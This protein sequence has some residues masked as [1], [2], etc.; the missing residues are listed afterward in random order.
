MSKQRKK[1]RQRWRTRQGK[2]SFTGTS[3]EEAGKKQTKQE[4][5]KEENQLDDEVDDV[6]E[7]EEARGVDLLGVREE[8][9]ASRNECRR[10]HEE[11]RRLEDVVT[12][13]ETENRQLLE[14][15]GKK[16]FLENR[17][18][19][20]ERVRQWRETLMQTPR[21]PPSPPSSHR[22]SPSPSPSLPLTTPPSPSPLPAPSPLPPPSHSLPLPPSSLVSPPLPQPR[23]LPL[24]RISDALSWEEC[25]QLKRLVESEIEEAVLCEMEKPLDL[26]EELEARERLSVGRLDQL[27]RAIQRFDLCERL[28]I[29]E[30]PTKAASI[31]P[32]AASYRLFGQEQKKDVDWEVT[33]ARPKGKTQSVSPSS[34]PS[35]LFQPPPST[36]SAPCSDDDNVVCGS[37]LADFCQGG[38]GDGLGILYVVGGEN[39]GL[40]EDFL[41]RHSTYTVRQRSKCHW[42]GTTSYT[43]DVPVLTAPANHE[44]WCEKKGEDAD[45]QTHLNTCNW[46]AQLPPPPPTFSQLQTPT[47]RGHSRVVFDG[48]FAARQ[49]S[50]CSWAKQN[51]EDQV[52]TVH[53]TT[54][55]VGGQKDWFWPCVFENEGGG[56]GRGSGSNGFCDYY[57]HPSA[58]K[59]QSQVRDFGFDRSL[60]EITESNEYGE[61]SLLSLEQRVQE[62]CALVERVVREREEREQFMREIERKEQL[63]REQRARENRE[64]E[65][66]E[67]QE[68]ERWPPQQESIVPRS[69]WL[70]EHYQ[71]YCQVRF[72]CCTQFYPCHRCHNNSDTCENEEAKACHATHLKCSHCQEEQEI[73]EDSAKCRKC[74]GK[75]SAYFCPICKH[76]TSVDKLPYHCEKCGICRIHEDK[77]FHCEVCNVCLDKRLQGNHK[78]RPDSGHD[79]CCICLEDAFSGCQILPCSHKVH[80]ECAIAMIQNGVRNCPICRH[81]LYSPRYA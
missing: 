62:A 24:R 55:T 18:L 37:Y 2:R 53:T 33:G 59:E 68:A 31:T 25:S 22:L 9:A 46:L 63:I 50:S 26:F 67:A 79:E 80:R 72:P 20:Q 66:R 81:P 51:C 69:K 40:R 61:D 77:S 78:C 48:D 5:E 36:P 12:R 23:R 10:Q 14:E 57:R 42:E 30:E 15:L 28:Q 74:S 7:Q 56:G 41:D 65:E 29:Q 44:S 70:C 52:T 1:K 76:F 49:D 19:R 47:L 43:E 73:G 11:I 3:F 54:G 60:G 38:E 4:D 34:S 39:S 16:Q 58:E 21:P 17:E 75:L 13:Y 71:R 45:R 32:T 64:R 6:C 27:L 8:L 35:L